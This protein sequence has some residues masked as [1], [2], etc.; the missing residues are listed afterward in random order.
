MYLF[1]GILKIETRNI[2]SAHSMHQSLQKQ[3]KS[4]NKWKTGNF[5]WKSGG[6]SLPAIAI[7]Y[8]ELKFG[9]QWNGIKRYYLFKKDYEGQ[10]SLA[11]QYT[12]TK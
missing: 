9:N 3:N 2:T 11:E 10:K 8:V 1:K 5:Y 4:V 6:K 12:I 7:K